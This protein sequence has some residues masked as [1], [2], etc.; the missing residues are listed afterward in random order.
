MAGR[1]SRRSGIDRETLP[2]IRNWSE[3]P[4]GGTEM[5]TVPPWRAISG[6]GTFLEVLK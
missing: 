5:V 4:P 2:E 3:D 1:L 6:H